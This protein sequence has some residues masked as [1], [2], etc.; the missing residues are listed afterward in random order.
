[1]VSSSSNK[2]IFQE[3][4]AAIN[5]LKTSIDQGFTF[6]YS[7]AAHG[8]GDSA[9]AASTV[10]LNRAN[11]TPDLSASLGATTY[12]DTPPNHPSSTLFP[13]TTLFRSD[14]GDTSTGVYGI[15]GGTTGGST[16]I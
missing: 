15:S 5:A 12:T 1:M 3:N 6:T 2:Y 10:H 11:N 16:V 13:Y 9:T 8:A 7:D 14:T 4:D